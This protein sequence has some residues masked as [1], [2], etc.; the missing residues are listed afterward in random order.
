MSVCSKG[1]PTSYIQNEDLH[2]QENVDT[3]LHFLRQ[4]YFTSN[5]GTIEI[6]RKGIL[7]TLF[8]RV[9]LH[10]HKRVPS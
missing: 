3:F 4:K 7:S 6:T 10:K 1:S 9:E 8:P 5:A 2:N